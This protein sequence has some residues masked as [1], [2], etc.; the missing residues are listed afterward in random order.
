P[1][2]GSSTWKLLVSEIPILMSGRRAGGRSGLTEEDLADVGL[3]AGAGVLG[4]DGD[5]DGAHGF[6]RILPVDA[7]V[8]SEDVARLRDPLAQAGVA[9]AHDDEGHRRDLLAGKDEAGWRRGVPDVPYHPRA[10]RRG[11][12]REGHVELRR[13]VVR[14]PAARVAALGKDDH[15]P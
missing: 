13:L 7:L 5:G 6:P 15:L 1:T 3:G 10:H 4:V 2:R 11:E 12:A 8:V 14:L 9:R